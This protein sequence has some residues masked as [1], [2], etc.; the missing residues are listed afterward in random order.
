[1]PP[2]EPDASISSAVLQQTVA[3]VSAAAINASMHP[4]EI[5]E[6]VFG[7]RLNQDELKGEKLIPI[8]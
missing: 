2:L 3:S 5:I 6:R 7:V 8:F 4:S 1:M